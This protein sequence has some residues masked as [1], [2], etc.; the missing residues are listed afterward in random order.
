MKSRCLNP[1]T[2][3]YK[4]YGGRGITICDDWVDS[5]ESFRDWAF[6][7]GYDETL[8][9]DRIDVDG[10]YEPG[11]CRWITGVAQANNRRSNVVF[12]Y[13]GET[14]NVTEWAAIV[15]IKPK[16]LFAR[17]ASGWSFEEA[18]TTEVKQYNK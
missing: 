2:E 13:N 16:T 3:R 4:D 5:F 17:L 7:N 18:I 12:T 11:N 9:I 10:N 1:N 15:G 8:T 14:H 6:E